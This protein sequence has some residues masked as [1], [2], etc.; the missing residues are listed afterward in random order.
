VQTLNEQ[1]WEKMEQA[2]VVANVQQAFDVTDTE[3][4]QAGETED[5][6]SAMDMLSPSGQTDAQTLALMLQEQLDAINNEIRLIQEEKENTEHRAE[7]LESQFGSLE[8]VGLAVHDHALEWLSPP[9]SGRSTPKS[10]ES[11]QK[12]YLQKYHTVTGSVKTNVQSP[13]Q[14]AQVPQVQEEVGQR[15]EIEVDIFVGM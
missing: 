9:H 12:D 11:P 13:R 1:E 6:F 4:G 10:N 7:E 5:I 15:L 2:H 3:S 8:T 14:P